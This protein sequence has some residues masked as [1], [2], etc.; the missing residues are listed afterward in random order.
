[1]TDRL[2]RL[3]L[4]S[5]RHR[6]RVIAAWVLIAVGLNILHLVLPPGPASG[7]AVPGSSSAIA[8]D[9]AEG[10]FGPALTGSSPLVIHDQSLDFSQPDGLKQL[11]AVVTAIEALGTVE[12]ATVP[13]PGSAAISTDGHTA[14]ISVTPTP[15][16]ADNKALGEQ[17][18]AAAASTMGDGADVAFGGVLGEALSVPDTEFSDIAGLLAAIVIM[19]VFFR[20]WAAVFVPL[21][22]ALLAVGTSLM[23]IG[24]LSRLVYI[25]SVGNNL[26]IMLGL[27]VGIDYALFMTTRYRSLL[28]QGVPREEAIG[29]AVS[30]SGS[31]IVFAGSTLVA[32]LLSLSLTGIHL[33]AA[34]GWASAIAVA[35]SVLASLTLVPAFFAIFG[36]RV[37]RGEVADGPTA[38]AQLDASFWGRFAT[39]VTTHPWTFTVVAV[40]IL[41]AL[42]APALRMTLGTSNP[43]QLPRDL[44]ISEAYALTDRGFGPGQNGPLIVVAELFTPA[45]DPD[46]QDT[47]L[48]AALAAA[49]QQAST[50]SPESSGGSS[51]AS[52]GDGDPRAKD[53]R[54]VALSSYLSKLQGID[55]VGSTYVGPSGGVAAIEIV[56]TTGPSDPETSALVER[57]QGITVEEIQ[58]ESNEPIAGMAV[59]VGGFT[60]TTVDLYAEIA[61]KTPLFIGIVIVLAFIVL[62]V[63]YRSLVIPLK[64]AVMNLISITA[65]YGVVTAVFVWGWGASLIG[66]DGPVPIDAYVPMMMFAVLFGLSMDY[67]VFLLTSFREHF[68][69]SGDMHVAVRRGLA[70]TGRLVSSAALIMVVVFGSFVFADD[71]LLKI[72]GV[73]LST[74]VIVDATVVRLMLVPAVMV[75]IRRGT[76]WLPRWLGRALP[77]IELEADPGSVQ[78]VGRRRGRSLARVAP[79]RVLVV[80]LSGV[81]AW[82][83]SVTLP[84]QAPTASAAITISVLAMVILLLAARPAVSQ[85]LTG[86]SGGGGGSLSAGRSALGFTIGSVLT[87]SALAISQ[88]ISAPVIADSAV[89][90]AIAVLVVAL[91]AVLVVSQSLWLPVMIGALVSGVGWS[92]VGGADASLPQIAVGLWLPA[93]V[94][95]LLAHVAD[96][97]RGRAAST[98]PTSQPEVHDTVDAP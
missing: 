51:G 92:L 58:A 55:H 16:V 71:P 97:W 30:A 79:A 43:G 12:S 39:R 46:E 5:A 49:E 96:S 21:G 19:F 61:A 63:A 50:A 2:Q 90:I 85:Q 83:I 47:S 1:M 11:S 18:L 82:W 67:E 66:L 8:Q 77:V 93:L 54:L 42:A 38:E 86:S 94:T 53:P 87:V 34:L 10:A 17:M 26:A 78:H 29:R 25:P 65:A 88:G 20:R 7:P 31:A 22:N 45:T 98:P 73:G 84:G 81:V 33:L 62:M 74:A 13:A 27:G 70:E 60:A 69:R 91:V 4:A 41:A 37:S 57:L 64:A 36:D 68:A 76:W 59:Y 32:A 95:A 44:T 72:F 14:L 40:V 75:L 23:L 15:A 28:R 6:W 24:V 80:I 48:T 9:L 56:P 35:L 3:A 52:S 89:L